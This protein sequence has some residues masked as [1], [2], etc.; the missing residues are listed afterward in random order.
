M[1]ASSVKVVDLQL[2]LSWF[3]V[4]LYIP[5][6]HESKMSYLLVWGNILKLGNNVL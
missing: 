1:V 6:V 4:R 3:L 5:Y 2:I